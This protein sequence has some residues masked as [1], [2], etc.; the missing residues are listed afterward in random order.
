MHLEVRAVPS[1]LARPD[2]ATRVGLIVP[3]G[4][5]TAVARNRLKRRLRELVRV[6]VLPQL[7]P[8]DLVIRA[9]PEAYAA[10]FDALALEIEQAIKQLSRTFSPADP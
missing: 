2:A 1:P 5:Q 9:R 4:R 7:I 3:K 8:S 10:T 6:R